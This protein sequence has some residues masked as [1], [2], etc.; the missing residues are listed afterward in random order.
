MQLLGKILGS[1]LH[2]FKERELLARFVIICLVGYWTVSTS[3]IE[4]D[5]FRG[6]SES[7]VNLNLFYPEKPN[8]TLLLLKDPYSP[9][10]L[11]W[12]IHDLSFY[13]GRYWLYWSPLP[14]LIYLPFTIAGFPINSKVAALICLICISVLF[15]A[16]QN[17]ESRSVTRRLRSSRFSLTALFVVSSGI[18]IALRRP[19]TYEIPILFAALLSLLAIFILYKGVSNTQKG[20]S[21]RKLILIGTLL[22]MAIW[23]RPSY[24]G[25]MIVV[26][27]VLAFWLEGRIKEKIANV[28]SLLIG[29]IPVGLFFFAYNQSRFNDPWEIGHK[30]QIA[31]ISND[32]LGGPSIEWTIRS[33]AQYLIGTPRFLSQFPFLALDPSPIN[34]Y[35][36]T[37]V[38]EPTIGLIWICPAYLLIFS[39]RYLDLTL[40]KTDPGEKIG[41]MCILSGNINLLITTLLIGSTSFRYILD[42]SILIALGT[43]LLLSRHIYSNNFV[44][45]KQVLRSK[46]PSKRRPK[47]GMQQRTSK[48]KKLTLMVLASIGCTT[49]LL[50]SLTGYYDPLN[51]I[52]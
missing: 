21:S 26:L 8:P 12:A 45:D 3:V 11:Q 31:V 20:I 22:S 2:F 46:N 33:F 36:S 25:T 18:L 23:C 1:K 49:S 51:L 39:S 30:Y 50:L 38:Y 13:D 10:S 32:S 5:Y 24:V 19:A 9:A 27:V 41:L 43:M 14:A 40:E 35:P 44:I 52:R 6:L 7:F 34:P 29:C 16:F 17:S 28:V 4:N 47:E 37:Y 15:F 48:S 42:G